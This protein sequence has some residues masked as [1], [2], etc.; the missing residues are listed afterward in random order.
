MAEPKQGTHNITSNIVFYLSADDLPDQWNQKRV[1]A[2]TTCLTVNKL[3]EKTSYYF[4]VCSECKDGL[5]PISDTSEPITTKMMLP[6]KP[7]KPRAL[8]ITENSIELEWTKPEYGAHN[9]TSYTVLYGS[10]A[11]PPDE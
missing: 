7:G 9:V 6:S 10:V 4:R 1:E 3:S 2:G 8:T 5:G 11:D